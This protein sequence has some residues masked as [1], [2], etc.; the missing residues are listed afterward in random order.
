MKIPRL[1]D[2]QS[3]SESKKE[4]EN[5]TGLVYGIQRRRKERWGRTGHGRGVQE[6]PGQSPLISKASNKYTNK[7][8][9]CVCLH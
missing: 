8:K 4:R 6:S 1:W 3:G 2:A 9:I 5:C 7:I